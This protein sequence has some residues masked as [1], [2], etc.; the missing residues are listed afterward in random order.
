[1]IRYGFRTGDTGVVFSSS[2]CIASLICSFR[3]SGEINLNA[4][5]T[6]G[7][8]RIE[9]TYEYSMGVKHVVWISLRI[10]AP[11]HPFTATFASRFGVQLSSYEDLINVTSIVKTA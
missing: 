11:H 9:S 6:K 3:A 1:M 5:R 8:V 10:K 7:S 4:I 2:C